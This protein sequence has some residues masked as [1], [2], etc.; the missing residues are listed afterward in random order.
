M[1]VGN[2]APSNLP[3]VLNDGKFGLVE[4]VISAYDQTRR[5]Q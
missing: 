5:S 4:L 2:Q 1:V 3:N